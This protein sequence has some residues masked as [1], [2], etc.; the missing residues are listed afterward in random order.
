MLTPG[1]SRIAESMKK[2][3]PMKILMN[4]YR[5]TADRLTMKDV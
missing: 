3:S 2:P 5:E 4:C 1:I